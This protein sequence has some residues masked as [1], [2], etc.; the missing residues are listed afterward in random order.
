M[1][2]WLSSFSYGNSE[3][4]RSTS[5][6]GSFPIDL[7]SIGAA[8]SEASDNSDFESSTDASR[9]SDRSFRGVSSDESVEED[10]DDDEDDD[11]SSLEED[12][13]D[14][15]DFISTGGAFFGADFGSSFGVARSFDDSDMEESV[16]DDSRSIGASADLGG[17]CR[18]RAEAEES[19][20]EDDSEDIDSVCIGTN[21]SG[22]GSFCFVG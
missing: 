4:G 16:D 14:V 17:S 18:G 5:I 8:S 1:S 10:E 19:D 11:E 12:D 22:G 13:T 2:S 20:E 3:D 21:F 15:E 9:G 6:G 7:D